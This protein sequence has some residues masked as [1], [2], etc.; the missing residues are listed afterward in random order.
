MACQLALLQPR[1]SRAQTQLL[2]KPQR[3]HLAHQKQAAGN[4]RQAQAMPASPARLQPARGAARSEPRSESCPSEPRSGTPPQA[5]QAAPQLLARFQHVAE[6][7]RR[8]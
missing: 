5:P 8:R 2:A 4:Q 1:A 3:L 7:R 6:E